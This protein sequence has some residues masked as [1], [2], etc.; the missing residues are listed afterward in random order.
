MD[1]N[2]FLKQVF[3][4]EELEKLLK[5]VEKHL[6]I[7]KKNM[8][9]EVRFHFTYMTLI[10]IGIY[11]IAKKGYRV[12]SRPGHHKILIEKLS[13]ILSNEDIMLIG[14]KMRR[15]RNMDFYS[16]DGMI[17][18]TEANKD[19]EFVEEIYKSL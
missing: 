1:K 10:K 13:E 2:F 14:D 8:E 3:S 16:A 18:E 4:A 9:P 6:A 11:L 19:F 5:S 15:R 12:K 17:T 7:S